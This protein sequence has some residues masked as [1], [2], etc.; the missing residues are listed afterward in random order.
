MPSRL[1]SN[2]PACSKTSRRVD[3]H[4]LETTLQLRVTC[5]C[6][7]APRDSAGERAGSTVL[8]PPTT[9]PACSSVPSE[10]S[11]CAPTAPTSARWI[12]SAMHERRP[13]AAEALARERP[14][15]LRRS[16]PRPRRR[17]A[18]PTSSPWSR[19]RRVCS[20][21]SRGLRG[22]CCS[23]APRARGGCSRMNSGPSSLR[24][25]GH[26]S[27]AGALPGR[28]LGRARLRLGR[29]GLR[30]ARRRG[31]G[32]LDRPPDDRGGT[33]RR[34]RGRRRGRDARP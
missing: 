10:F 12:C 1:S 33:G 27:F 21:S 14:G 20:R 5:S 25:T 8:S 34:S 17:W 13:G 23:R 2:P 19:R 6:R 28:R 32:A 18:A 9:I 26:W 30:R 11:S 15:R 3:I 4:A 31:A 7:F 16:A 24:C 29:P 22:A